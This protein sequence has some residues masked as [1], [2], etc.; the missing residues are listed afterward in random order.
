MDMDVKAALSLV[1]SIVATAST[2][3][4]WVIQFL[5]K[6]PN[7]RAY[8]VSL[9]RF[10][11]HIYPLDD[12]RDV[13]PLLLRVA[14]ANH[15]TSADAILDVRFRVRSRD[16]AWLPSRPYLFLGGCDHQVKRHL[17]SVTALP[18]NLPPK[19]TVTL[20]RYL[21]VPI[22]KGMDFEACVREPFEVEVTLVSLTGPRF[23]RVI[24]KPERLD[25]LSEAMAE[26]LVM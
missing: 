6:L 26:E 11:G 9:N 8:W 21:Q 13:Q 10:H 1:F 18:V 19:Q 23:R 2:V 4:L 7:M 16:G 14:V 12:T 22:A 25:E 15:S 17:D 5:N 20:C 24:V 3:V